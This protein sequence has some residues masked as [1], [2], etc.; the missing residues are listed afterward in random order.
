MYQRILVPVDGSPTSG[1]GLAE[2]T[3]LAKLTQGRLLLVH[4]LE[5]MPYA[6]AG[7]GYGAM[8]ADIVG[9]MTEAGRKLLNEAQRRVEGEGVPVET[10]LVERMD[11]R[12]SDS[13]SEE[14]DAWHAD[15]VVLGTHGRRGVQRMLL[16]SDAELIV[17]TA[18]VPV[19]LVRGD[20]ARA[21]R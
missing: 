9:M 12:L 19:L 16:G 7:E 17:R 11:A 6:L 13:I 5:P 21:A 1:L 4:L 15:L 10:K 3:R 18:T 8:T 14:I 20:P 2:A